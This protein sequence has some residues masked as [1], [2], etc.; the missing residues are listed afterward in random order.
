MKGRGLTPPQTVGPF[1]HGLLREGLNVLAAPKAVGD[2]I[3]IE[4][5]VYDGNR[6]PVP[7][8]MIEI[9]QANANGYYS[10]PIDQRIASLDPAFAGYGRAG[11]NDAGHFW[12]E[13]IRPGRVPLG[14]S[15]DQAPHLNVAVSARGLLH[16]LFTRLYFDDEAAANARDPVLRDIPRDRRATMLA[17]KSIGDGKTVYRFDIVLQGQDETV[18][19]DL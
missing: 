12:F 8:A 16:H 4:G 7:D 5:H 11:T 6:A 1:F 2:R 9:W 17:K 15:E 10:H 18:F 13:T 14:K 19:F 3:R